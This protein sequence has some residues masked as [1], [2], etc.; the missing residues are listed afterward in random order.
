[1]PTAR[2][3][4][5]TLQTPQGYGGA[6]RDCWQSLD[7]CRNVQKTRRPCAR[8]LT[9]DVPFGRATQSWAKLSCS[10]LDGRTTVAV[11]AATAS[12]QLFPEFS[13]SSVSGQIV[14]S[15]KACRRWQLTP[16]GMCKS[17]AG[18]NVSKRESEFVAHAIEAA[19]CPGRL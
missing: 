10:G 18:P 11:V 13:H 2:D 12:G 15:K 4:S 7:Q 6:L 3:T 9:S 5:G 17:L 1:M 16:P 14:E 8:S 19:I